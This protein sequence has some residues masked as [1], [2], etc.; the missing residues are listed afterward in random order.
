MDALRAAIEDAKK[1]V[2]KRK[3]IKQ[4]RKDEAEAS[5]STDESKQPVSGDEEAGE[6]AKKYMKRGE[7]KK[8]ER[9]LTAEQKVAKKQAQAV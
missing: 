9:V 3:F 6:P 1:D 4:L 5:E 7:I 8:L 2:L